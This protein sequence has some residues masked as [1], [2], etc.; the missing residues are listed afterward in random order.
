MPS[1][2]PLAFQWAFI[3]TNA[4]VDTMGKDHLQ[5]RVHALCKYVFPHQSY[6]CCTLSLRGNQ[7]ACQHTSCSQVCSGLGHG[8]SQQ[9][10]NDTQPACQYPHFAFVVRR[11]FRPPSCAEHKP[12]PVTAVAVAV[13][14]WPFGF[15]VWP[16]PLWGSTSPCWPCPAVPWAQAACCIHYHHSCQCCQADLELL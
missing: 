16:G 3:M 8:K 15:S 5:V 10:F 4:L 14:N 11:S 12:C 1:R 6:R 13:L 2:L 9:R 7:V